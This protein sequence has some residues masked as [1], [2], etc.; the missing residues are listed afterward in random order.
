MFD[1]EDK[2]VIYDL[3][4]S[5]FEGRKTHSSLAQFG[6]N[7]QKRNDRRQVVFTG[8][9]NQQGFIRHSRIYEGNTADPTTLPDMLED[10]KKHSPQHAK[11]TVVIDAGLASEENLAIIRNAGLTYVCVARSGL[12]DYQAH[13]KEQKVVIKDRNGSPIELAMVETPTQPDRWMYV[14][15]E[16]KTRK[17]RAIDAQL[18]ARFEQDLQTAKAAL[19]KKGG[20]KKIEK[21]YERIGRI[22]E[23][24]KKVQAKYTITIRQEAGKATAITWTLKPVNPQKTDAKLS[25]QNQGVYFIRTNLEVAQE[26]QLWQIYNTIREVEATFRCLKSDLQIRPIHHQKDSRVEAHIYVTILAYQLVN[27]IRYLLKQKNIHHDWTNIIRIMSSQQMATVELKAEGKTL[28]VRRPSRPSKAAL[29]IYKALGIS[30]MP[31]QKSKYVVY[32]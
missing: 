11:R 19:T 27:T 13:V 25:P 10:L 9:I 23:K 17:E 6:K 5:Y 32:H 15:S 28:G 3:T 12:K 22:K 4:N 14:K 7:K 2:L 8:V 31:K 16:G 1:L 20:T 29:G 21:V 24:H 26:V 30:S 18:T